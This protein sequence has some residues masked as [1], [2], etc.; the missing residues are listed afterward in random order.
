MKHAEAAKMWLKKRNLQA[1]K[2]SHYTE[3][4]G[5]QRYRELEAIIQAGWTGESQTNELLGHIAEYHRIYGEDINNQQELAEAIYNTA[6]NCPGY[7]QYCNHQQDLKRR[8]E[9]WAKSAWK[10]LR[11]FG[12]CTVKTYKPKL[13]HENQNRIK[14]EESKQKILTVV[15]ELIAEGKKV[16]LNAVSKQSGL[17]RGTV[18]KYREFIDELCSDLSPTDSKVVYTF[19][20]EENP[21]QNVN[22]NS[23]SSQSNFPCPSLHSKGVYNFSDESHEEPQ[24]NSPASYLH[25]EGIYNFSDYLTIA[26]KLQAESR[27]SSAEL[28]TTDDFLD[29]ASELGIQISE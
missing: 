26:A 13:P 8:C 4:R 1:V 27:N 22:P 19:H 7:I 9:D 16:T 3:G 29:M 17:N 10:H 24:A 2:S 6:I 15:G 14:A 5:T 28:M 11:P 21:P 18:T 23:E 25:S 12:S 20:Y